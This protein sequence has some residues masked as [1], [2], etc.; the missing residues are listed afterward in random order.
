[1]EIEA[2]H[3]ESVRSILAKYPYTFYAFGSKGLV[4]CKRFSD[5]DLTFSDLIPMNI[6]AHIEE[7]FSESDWLFTIDLVDFNLCDPDFQELIRKDWERIAGPK[8]ERGRFDYYFP[9]DGLLRIA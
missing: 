8:L 5:L 2:R 9:S 1:M 4:N 3:L 7:D 6:Q